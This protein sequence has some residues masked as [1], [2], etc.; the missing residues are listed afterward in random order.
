MPAAR[1][2]LTTDVALSDAVPK[3]GPAEVFG[4]KPIVATIAEPSAKAETAETLA[5]AADASGGKRAPQYR[6]LLW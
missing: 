2:T 1:R 4:R 5:L 6:G 3:R